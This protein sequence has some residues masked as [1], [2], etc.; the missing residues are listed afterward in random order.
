MAIKVTQYR[1]L[2]LLQIRYCTRARGNRDRQVY[3]FVIQYRKNYLFISYLFT[4]LLN[5]FIKPPENEHLHTIGYFV[6]DIFTSRDIYRCVGVFVIG[7]TSFNL[8]S[9]RRLN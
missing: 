8:M 6:Y 7:P 5:S 1:Y 4:Y 3:M 9:S 2:K